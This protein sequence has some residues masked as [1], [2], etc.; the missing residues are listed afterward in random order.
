MMGHGLNVARQFLTKGWYVALVSKQIE[1]ETHHVQSRQTQELD[2]ILNGK[3]PRAGAVF[4]IACACNMFVSGGI[5]KDE[6][7]IAS[8]A[9]IETKKGRVAMV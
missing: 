9:K 6:I 5:G 2:P 7:P 1:I 8:A 3:F 4:L